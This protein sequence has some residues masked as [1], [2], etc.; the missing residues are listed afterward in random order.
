[1]IIFGLLLAIVLSVAVGAAFIYLKRQAELKHEEKMK[2]KEMQAERDA[3][4]WDE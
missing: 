2:E 1:L 4:M 3:Y